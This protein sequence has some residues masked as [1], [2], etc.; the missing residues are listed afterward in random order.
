MGEAT[1]ASCAML[2]KSFSHW[3]ATH[4][5]APTAARS[6]T[7]SA[8]RNRR[9][10]A[11]GVSGEHGNRTRQ[12]GMRLRCPACDERHVDRNK[13]TCFEFNLYLFQKQAVVTYI[14]VF[15]ALFLYRLLLARRFQFANKMLL[16]MHICFSRIRCTAVA[17]ARG[18]L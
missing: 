11:P 8:G 6:I 7:G 5:P 9:T 4:S 15:L 18:C 14:V 13:R 16:C 17:F 12:S 3:E 10:P 2:T 1:C